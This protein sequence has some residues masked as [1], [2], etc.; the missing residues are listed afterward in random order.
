MSVLSGFFRSSYSINGKTAK[1]YSR[2]AEMPELGRKTVPHEFP[3]S[4]NRYVED[5]GKIA[6]KFKLEIEIQETTASSYKRSRNALMTALEQ[7]GVGSL[8]HPTLGK[9][10]V[11]PQPASMTE[12]FINENGLVAFQITFL[13]STLNI[14]PE[15]T[16]G[17]KGFLARLYD[18][19]FGNNE[20]VFGQ[21]QNYYNQGIELFN[22]GRD[23]L[24]DATSNI[25]DVVSTAN[26]ITDEVAAFNTDIKDFSSSII[27]LMQTPAD[28]ARRFT[29]IFNNVASITDDF[30]IMTNIVLQIF[31]SG[32]RTKTNG[33]SALSTQLNANKIATAD[34]IDVACLTVAYLATTNIDYTSQDQI[35]EILSRLNDAFDTLDPDSVNE[36]VYYDLQEMRTQN[37]LLLQDLQ[38]TLPFYVSIRT[39]S[40]PSSVLSY[41]LYG[42]SSRAGEIESLNG[43]EDPAFVSGNI[44]VLSS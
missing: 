44:I 23:T 4:S 37:R 21:A 20:S 19:T 22:Q 33:S 38:T 29:T 3:N 35:D 18:S 36:D 43:I 5:F 16:T 9:K 6:G 11:V 8:T 28:L 25:D 2:R 34:Y 7:Q 41:N 40:I 1:F 42:D 17:N 39:N 10:K 13:E 26:G 15:S 12:D 14:F 31:G 32:D 30:Q 24:Q 27:T